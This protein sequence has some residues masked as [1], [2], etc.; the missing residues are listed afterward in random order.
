MAQRTKKGFISVV[1]TVEMCPIRFDKE[2]DYKAKLTKEIVITINALLNSGG[3]T[4]E[5]LYKSN[6]VRKQIDDCI[7][8]MEQK[9][10]NQM[11]SEHFLLLVEFEAVSQGIHIRIGKARRLFVLNYNMYFPTKSQVKAISPSASIASVVAMI[12][13]SNKTVEA[14]LTPGYEYDFVKDKQVKQDEDTNL[15]W[16]SLKSASSKCVTLAD[17]ITNPKNKLSCYVSAFGNCKGGHIYYGINDDGIV[18]GENVTDQ[19]KI[20]ENVE[21]AMEKLVW[22]M[23]SGP[24]RGKEWEIFFVPVKDDSGK[25]ITSTFII[26]VAV[27]YCPGGVFTD[28]P[29]GYHIV[30][31]KVEKM[32]V[33]DWKKYFPGPSQAISA[34]IPRLTWSSKKNKRVYQVYTTKLVQFR[35]DKKTEEF[36]TFCD[37]ASKKY[38]ATCASLVATAERAAIACKNNE[39]ETIE[40]LIDGFSKQL[41]TSDAKDVSF[42]EVRLL[43]MKSRVERAK[44]NFAT[45]YEIAKDG[46][47]QLQNIQPDFLSVWFYIHAAAVATILSTKETDHEKYLE[48]LLVKVKRISKKR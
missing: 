6:P 44:K 20:T 47:Q 41:Y 7:K 39:F 17:R 21:K 33:E 27:A 1:I 10:E 42:F 14:T 46:L 2:K 45:S 8:C 13:K 35:N 30:D 19:D 23:S 24:R 28:F 43:C 11:G 31:G 36:D 12:S 3:G 34:K 38:A 48:L 9:I 4:L 37:L 18:E 40:S 15:Q 22:P 29:E 16:K 32:K 25:A 26:V 5:L